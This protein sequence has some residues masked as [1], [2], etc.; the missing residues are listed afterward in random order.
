ML[1]IELHE[2]ICNSG[3]YHVGAGQSDVV[4]SDEPP[5]G[6]ASL[7]FTNVT[8]N[9]TTYSNQLFDL[10]NDF[11]WGLVMVPIE[12]FYSAWQ[13]VELNAGATGSRYDVTGFF[14]NE[15]GLQW[16]S[17][18]EQVGTENDQFGGWLICDWWHGAPQ[19]FFRISYYSGYEAPASCADVYLMPQ[20]I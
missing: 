1:P 5:L 4:F 15:T 8:A 18:P 16:T 9:G 12:Q 20:Y 19:L 2:L 6:N 11:P 3:G 10:G 7:A 14:I 13:P 17:S